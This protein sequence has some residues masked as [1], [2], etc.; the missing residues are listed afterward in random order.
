MFETALYYPTID[1]KNDSW[2]KS[3][4]LFWDRIET[5]VPESEEHPYHRRSTMMLQDEHILFP[6]RVNPF[7][8]EVIG[9]EQDVIKYLN[10]SEGKRSFVRPWF[11]PAK[12]EYG[13]GDDGF[14]RQ[15][16]R[17]FQERQIQDVYREFYIHVEKLPMILRE[18]LSGYENKDGYLL[19]SRGFMSFYMT[20][21]ANRI[22]QNKGMALLTDKV[23]QNVLSNKIL[24]EGLSLSDKRYNRK[25][26]RGMMY[27]IM[28]D[29]IKIDPH[30][31]MERIVKFKRDRVHELNSFRKEMDKLTTCYTEGMEIKDVESELRRVYL[32][33][34][35]PSVDTI[36]STLKDAKISWKAGAAGCVLTGV[37]PTLLSIG[38]GVE[39][40]IVFGVCQGL[41]FAV[42]ATPY[43]LK[44]N[45]YNGSPYAYLLKMEKE[46]FAHSRF[47]GIR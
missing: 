46:L 25:I 23:Y 39:P 3:A 38:A 40:D 27:R 30:T 31:P 17:E 15:L 8:E 10:T 45:D 43:L 33:Q 47:Q 18:K 4:A 34:I 24:V 6:H 26:K 12:R 13:E 21:L 7:C 28:V 35:I 14:Y 20:L 32:S 1:I 19:A 44:K 41:G 36:K 16:K 9:I 37:I 5:I 11:K 42:T 2:L 29:D 22:C